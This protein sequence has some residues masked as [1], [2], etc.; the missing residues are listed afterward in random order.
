MIK[1]LLI[2]NRLFVCALFFASLL[3]VGN[4]VFAQSKTVKGT[5]VDETGQPLPGVAV[6]IQGTARGTTTDFDGEFTLGLEDQDETLEFS[7]IGYAKKSVEIG[8]TINFNINMEVD[9]EQ[10]EEVLVI[11]YGSTTKKDATGSVEAV[12]ADNFN[13][14]AINSPQGLLQ[15]K[16]AGVQI[17]TGGGAP[18]SGSTIRIRGG[19]SLSASNDPLIVIDGVPVDNDGVSGMRNP[20][21]AINPA[22]I[23]SMTVLKDAS[24]TAIYGS[25]ASN[26]VIIITTKKGSQNDS[27]I[28]VNYNGSV[29]INTLNDQIDVLSADQYRDIMSGRPGEHLLGDANTNW[30][31]EV[32][33]TS[34]STDHNVGVSGN[35]KGW[36]PYRASVGYTLDNGTLE[37]SSMDRTTLNLNL[38]PKF[39]DDHLSVNASVKGMFVNNKFGNT[40]AIG[41]AVAY[42]PTQS[43]Y[44]SRF[45]HYGGYHTW[46]NSDDPLSGRSVNAPSNPMAMINQN[47]NTSTVNRSIGNA[48]VDYKV[49]GF[50]DLTFKVNAGYDYSSSKGG[51]YEG[52]E[53]SWNENNGP[54]GSDDKGGYVSDYT[55][56]KRNELLDVYAQYNKEIG[57][58]KFD[59]MGGYSWQ[60][61][62]EEGSTY[63][64]NVYGNI[65][66]PMRLWATEYYLMSFFGR[67]NYTFNN[68]YMATVTVRQDG[69]SRF[70]QNNRWGTFPSLALAWKINEEP[71][72]QSANFVS[73]LKL[74]AGVGVTGQQDIGQGNF[75]YMPTYTIGDD[76]SKYGFYNPNTGQWEYINTTRPGGYDENIKWE[77]TVTYNAGVDFGFFNDRVTGSAEAYYRV[78]NDLLN[79]IPVPGGSNLTNMLLTNVGSM[80]NKGVELSLNTKI[81]QRQDFHWD[82]GVNVTWNDSKITKLTTV[83]DPSYEGVKV[84]GIAGGTG[85]TVQIHRVGYAPYSFLVYEQIYDDAGKPIEGAYVDRNGDG[86]IDEK[87]KYIAGDPM[88]NLYFG[89]TTRLSYKN[90]EFSLAGRAQ[91]G[92]QVYN[93]VD[94]N[95]S[96]YDQLYVSANN[97]TNNVTT[98]IYNTGFQTRQL[99]SDYYV[100]DANFLRIDNIMI[101]Y[102]FNNFL[103]GKSNLRV[104]GTVNNP[105]VFSN[106]KGIDPEI[107]G[108]IDNNMY[109]R[110]TTYMIGFNVNF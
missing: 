29:S 83:D 99:H 33:K 38:S 73:D 105:C 90:W 8:T 82:F 75:P 37:G 25:R 22:D 12:T 51:I 58:H 26:G 103:K 95:N 70:S 36:L 67:A 80:E 11:G 69:T 1:N 72:M 53:T 43:V 57:K 42:D 28:N 31:N 27:S 55:Q 102:N 14:G 107:Q 30:Q 32:F 2:T 39:L 4:G 5:V 44:D 71:W 63:E 96:A 13:K 64:N 19:S 92:A 98:D 93:N 76:N 6:I 106:Y 68:K 85:E 66:N 110:P 15:G 104:F 56:D 91:F 54:A 109:P 9:A 108:G 86:V 41:S 3:F 10:L 52:V 18:G 78:T 60:H 40:D 46:T 47:S 48:Q 45:E 20:L 17:T 21:N 88:A 7:Y 89:F 101:G 61:F 24:A 97:N 23:E 34:V 77:E 50:E 94:S 35:V 74:R 81:I 100:Q 62:Y 49:H 65:D 87:D 84:G 59:V 16:V 79:V